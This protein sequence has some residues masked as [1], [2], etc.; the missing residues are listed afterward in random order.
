MAN[1]G[2]FNGLDISGAS[3][4][5]PPYRTTITSTTTFYMVVEVGWTTDPANGTGFGYIRAEKINN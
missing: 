5:I 2:A 1:F 3:G 4:V